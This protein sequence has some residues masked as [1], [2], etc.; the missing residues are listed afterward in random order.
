[1]MRIVWK[2]Y[3]E[4]QKHWAERLSAL[5]NESDPS[6]AQRF[7]SEA[8]RALQTVHDAMLAQKKA[9]NASPRAL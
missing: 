1:M 2:G 3:I 8:R 6:T 9:C 5:A 7:K 4:D